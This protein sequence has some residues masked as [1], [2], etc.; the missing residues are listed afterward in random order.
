MFSTKNRVVRFERISTPAKSHGFVFPVFVIGLAASIFAIVLYWP[1]P[2]PTLT[3]SPTAIYNT[4]VAP[5]QTTRNATHRGAG[6][7]FKCTVTTVY[8]GD[9]PIHCREGTSI[10]LQAVAA[11]EMDGRCLPG[12]PC[13]SASGIAAKRELQSIVLHHVLRCEQTGTS[14]NRVTAVCWTESGL[15]VNCAM[16]RSGKALLWDKYDRQR[17]ICG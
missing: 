2:S 5:T 16:V 7:L 11:R 1:T 13:P 6:A 14:Y 10:R 8:D 3:Q 15:E 4:Y 9:G 17:R 12:H